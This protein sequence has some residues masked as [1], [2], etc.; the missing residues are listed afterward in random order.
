MS[1]A[2]TLERPAEAPHAATRPAPIPATLSHYTCLHSAQGIERDRV[3]RPHRHPLF[4]AALVWLTDLYPPDR[5]SL[6][7]TANYIRCDR[8]AVRVRV[9]PG[10]EVIPWGRWA[11]DHRVPRAIREILEDGALPAHWWVSA[12]PVPVHTIHHRQEHRHG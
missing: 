7:L 3:I 12:E 10:P 8:T 11:H 9:H 4:G 2:A 1:C 6:G 5:L